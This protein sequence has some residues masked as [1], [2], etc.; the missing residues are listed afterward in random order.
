[1]N[2]SDFDRELEQV[3]EARGRALSDRGAAHAAECADCGQRWSD[4]R[5]ID[6]AII[7][8]RPVSCPPSLA[9]SVV[10]RLLGER[11][12]H[13]STAGSG[14][15]PDSV[16][17]ATR[18]KTHSN[19]HGQ[20]IVVATVA[21]CLLVVLGFGMPTR[22]PSPDRNVAVAPANHLPATSP[23]TSVQEDQERN[24]VEVASSVAAV[25]NDLRAEY[26]G[27]AE[28]TSA[29]A[30]E[31]AIVL[32]GTRVVGWADPRILDT[33]PKPVESIET[34]GATKVAAAAP[35]GAVTVI[36]RS[37]GTQIGQAMDFLRV[38]V[39]E[40]IPRG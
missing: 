29:T 39:P 38:A 15:M 32:P 18:R 8:W 27:L 30:Q 20:W 26:R 40:S 14:V 11:M 9:D 16:S 4:A 1:M 13:D 12:L 36:G 5:L 31:F 7:A 3:V 23:V 35:Q 34:T 25:F 22:Q 28:E 2:C 6:A 19:T 21:A 10:A 33:S 17:A 24:S 37:I